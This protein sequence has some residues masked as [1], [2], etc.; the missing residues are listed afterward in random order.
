M[1]KDITFL[2][3]CVCGMGGSPSNFTQTVAARN[4]KVSFLI[5]YKIMG[6][7]N[8]TSF[9]QNDRNDRNQNQ[10]RSTHRRTLSIVPSTS[11][12]V[13]SLIQTVT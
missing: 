13:T 11:C 2:F 12:T 8:F 5:P 6:L 1:K 3:T 4:L 9:E 7:G 10:Y